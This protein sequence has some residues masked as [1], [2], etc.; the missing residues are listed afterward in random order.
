MAWASLSEV[1]NRP[2]CKDRLA[3]LASSGAKMSEQDLSKEFGMISS[4]DDL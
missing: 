2:C 3:S 1:G 4:G